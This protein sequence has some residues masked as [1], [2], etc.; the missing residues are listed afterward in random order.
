VSDL[1]QG[2]KINYEGASGPMDFDRYHNV[3]GAWDV[4]QANGDAKGETTTLD[5]I[6]ATTIQQALKKEGAA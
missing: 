6:S 4:V 2:K 5:T 1:K 3:S